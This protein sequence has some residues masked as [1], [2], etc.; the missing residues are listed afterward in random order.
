[1]VTKKA[2]SRRK[3]SRNTYI[4]AAVFTILIFSLGLALGWII[5]ME[6]LRWSDSLNT[7]FD[8]DYKRL[9]FQS[10]YLNY[11]NNDNTSCSV[12][13][14]TLDNAISDL[15]YSLETFQQYEKQSKINKEDFQLI[16]RR[17]LLD[18]LRYWL[19]ARETKA[20]CSFDVV[21][22]LYFYSENNCPQCPNLGVV[23]TYYKK[24]LDQDLLIFPINV[25]LEKDENVIELLRKQYGVYSLPTL[26]IEDT[27]YEGYMD[28]DQLGS[29]ICGLYKTPK[30][31]CS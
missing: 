28:K 3:I 15:D 22:I 1:M 7:K 29:I 21:T 18:N 14:G 5:D 25:D 26:V 16:K 11:I 24:K 23:L 4:I 6:R 8:V 12:L 10:M 17:Y 30:A 27:K 13:Y 2:P 9:Q 19:I 20:K 31:G